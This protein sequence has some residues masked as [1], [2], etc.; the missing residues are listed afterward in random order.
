MTLGKLFGILVALAGI[1]VLAI[2]LAPA[3]AGPFHSHLLAQDRPGRVR[4]LSVLTG[5]G[6]DIGVFVRDAEA[7]VTVDEVRADSVAEKAGLKR[8]DVIVT[9]DGERVRSARQFSRLV[10]ETASGRT[11]TA[12]VL[13][14]AEQTD[15]RITIPEGRRVD[16][17]SDFA[18]RLPPFNFN[19][20]F[21]MPEIVS[22]RRLGITVDNLSDQLAEYFGAKG[23]VLVTAVADGSP[24]ARAE[25]RAGD[26]ITSIDG[27]GVHSR[28]ELVARV[29]GAPSDQIEIGIVRDKKATTV[30]VTVEPARRRMSRGVRL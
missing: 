28:E 3:A 19:F 7:G 12:T 20:D 25:L 16:L 15:I 27:Q 10:Q 14:D 24:A 29:H 26:V 23:G 30:K 8:S 4:D 17:F 18:D 5:R 13:R 9:F 1:G 2:A 22:G 11:I 21:D 6:A